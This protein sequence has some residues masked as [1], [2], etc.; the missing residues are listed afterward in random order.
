MLSGKVHSLQ[1]SPTI[2]PSLRLSSTV[3]RPNVIGGTALRATSTS[4]RESA[5]SVLQAP[6]NLTLTVNNPL[7]A[8]AKNEQRY[9]PLVTEPRIY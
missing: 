5:G 7:S 3:T 1:L 4:V 2:H 6:T 9:F 8:R